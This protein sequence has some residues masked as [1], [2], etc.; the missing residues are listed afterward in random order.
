LLTGRS[1][2]SSLRSRRSRWSIRT[3]LPLCA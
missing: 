1:F 3:A 2:R